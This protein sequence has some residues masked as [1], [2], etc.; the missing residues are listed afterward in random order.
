MAINTSCSGCGSALSIDEE[1]AGRRAKCPSCGQIYTV[2]Y[3]NSEQPA[4]SSEAIDLQLAEGLPNQYWMRATEGNIYGPVD[5][6]TLTLWF[7]E[8]RVGIGYHIRQGV[9]G[10]WKEA[11]LYRPQVQTNP[12]GVSGVA[13]A[14]SATSTGS[15]DSG[16]SGSLLHRYP[17]ADQGL[18]VLSC[19][20]L[21]WVT[22]CGFFGI[23][24]FMI[25]KNALADIDQ[26]RASPKDRSMV[27]V[28]FWIGLVNVVLNAILII[29]G[30]V[31][32]TTYS[33][34]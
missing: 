14:A 23:A 12:Y 29:I 19:S 5:R 10:V 6:D 16:Q 15:F 22:L 18:V 4:K 20:I 32:L 8:G 28:G 2:P 9:D 7:R 1:F 26:G 3:S 27:L 11:S 17:K 34:R 31:W 21:A 24:A 33:F 30:L 13:N 25:G